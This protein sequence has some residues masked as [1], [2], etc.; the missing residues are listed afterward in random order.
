MNEDEFFN[1]IINTKSKLLKND[2]NLHGRLI[3]NV[4][5]YPDCKD[6]PSENV[7]GEVLSQ[8]YRLIEENKDKQIIDWG[9]KNERN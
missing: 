3:K 9:L 7:S 1:Q 8:L 6:K 2:I 4:P 5:V